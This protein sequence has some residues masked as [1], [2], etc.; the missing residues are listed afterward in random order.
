MYLAELHELRKDMVKE[1]RIETVLEGKES[2]R[3]GIL[4]RES[5]S[6]LG[7]EATEVAWK[8]GTVCGH[9]SPTAKVVLRL[10]VIQLQQFTA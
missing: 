2:G 9:C 5:C 10:P 4:H 8:E 1:E 6:G 7:D 3:Q